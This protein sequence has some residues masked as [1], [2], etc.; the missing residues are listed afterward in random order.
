VQEVFWK[1][2]QLAKKVIN[3]LRDFVGTS[4]AILHPSTFPPTPIECEAMMTPPKTDPQ[5][6][7][8]DSLL[9]IITCF[10]YA[11]KHASGACNSTF[12]AKA[13]TSFDATCT[14]EIEYHRLPVA[15]DDNHYAQEIVINHASWP[16]FGPGN[17]SLT[18]RRYCL[19]FSYAMNATA[20]RHTT[21]EEVISQFRY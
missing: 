2:H 1:E 12:V 4:L 13:N 5:D 21:G 3:K 19:F 18:D 20:L 9:H 17:P 7:H 6:S 11:G 14:D 8:L 15:V 10:C 16:H